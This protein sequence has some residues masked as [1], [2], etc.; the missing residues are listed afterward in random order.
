M[1]KV[2]LPDEPTQI[3][4]RTLKYASSLLGFD[5]EMKSQ[6][7]LLEIFPLHTEI[8]EILSFL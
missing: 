6:E 2:Y 7:E 8:V 3:L 1:T 5:F 4:D